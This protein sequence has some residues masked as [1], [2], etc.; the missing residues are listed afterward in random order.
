[1]YA[2]YVVMSTMANNHLQFV[3][4]ANNLPQNSKRYLTTEHLKKNLLL[5][6]KKSKTG[7]NKDNPPILKIDTKN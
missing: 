7:S 3:Q 4:F 2:Q 1:M 6:S 5:G